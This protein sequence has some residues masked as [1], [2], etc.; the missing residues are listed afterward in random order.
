MTTVNKSSEDSL[1]IMLSTGVARG[2]LEYNAAIPYNAQEN[3]NYD[4][5]SVGSGIA[6][7]SPT[8]YDA[9]V[10]YDDPGQS[11]EHAQVTVEEGYVYP[12]S[13]DILQ[14]S[15]TESTG[16]MLVRIARFDTL[17]LTVLEA[18]ASGGL[19]FLNRADT[20]LV[21]VSETR[22][23]F[24]TQTRNDSLGINV[25]DTAN[26]FVT[27]SSSDTLSVSVA[28]MSMSDIQ[29]DVSSS[30]QLN[31]SIDESAEFDYTNPVEVYARYQ[32]QWV[33]AKP[34]VFRGDTWII[35]ETHYSESGAWG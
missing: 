31:V 4:F 5:E 28:D 33:L 19:V 8:Q 9:P 17:F 15:V 12:S 14:V 30:D 27:L 26:V 1:R 23:I 35:P 10:A 20:L 2:P 13:T 18:Q 29:V 3:Y 24:S 32:A 25:N 21:S 22:T 16:T 11:G 7:D 6:Y 34:F